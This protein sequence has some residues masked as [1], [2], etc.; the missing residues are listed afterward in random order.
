[1]YFYPSHHSADLVLP[2]SY[3]IAVLKMPVGDKFPGLLPESAQT[4]I[5]SFLFGSVNMSLAI[6]H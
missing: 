6:G 1:M 3:S 5:R 4:L 2:S